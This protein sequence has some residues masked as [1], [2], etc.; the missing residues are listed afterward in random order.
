MQLINDNLWYDEQRQ[1]WVAQYPFLYPRESLLGTKSVAMKS[2]ISTERTLMKNP[3]W[4]ITYQSQIQDMLDRGAAR[5]VPPEELAKF[6]GHIN[7]LPHL[8]VT[9]PNSESTPVRLCFDASR[10]QGGGPSLNKILA[11][12]PDRFLN[13]LAGVILR[14]RNGIVGIKADVKKMYN[15]VLLVEEDCFLQCF[16]WREMDT[17]QEPKTYQVIVNN[18]GVKPAGCIA[19]TALYKSADLFYTKYPDTSKQ[20]KDNSYVDDLGLTARN[21]LEAVERA[22][23]ADEILAHANM[24]VKKWV[25]SG[26]CVEAMDIGESESLPLD[27][28]GTERMLGVLWNAKD[29]EFQ[30]KVRINLSIL[31]KKVRLGP[32]LTKQDLISNPP[33]VL[34]RRQYYSQIQSLFDPIGFLSPVLLVAKILLRKTWKNGCEKLGWDESLPPELV[35]EMIDFF[36]ELFDLELITFSRS[37]LPKHEDVVGKPELV[38]FSDG[39]ILAFGSV[40]YIRWKL[41]SGSWWSKLI[42]SKSK[43]APKSRI[44]VP[45]LELNGACFLT[46][47]LYRVSFFLKFM[48]HVL[49]LSVYARNEILMLNY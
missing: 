49:Q 11:K 3:E 20:L 35:K 6:S 38:I 21:A 2:M 45:R 8:A 26:D 1:S 29:D 13:N 48:L 12:G 36:I 7:Y 19:T 15:A 46:L 41:N 32:D 22:K 14:F 23:Q 25:F 28:V 37:L 39:S 47:C 17:G 40:A 43:I 5:V 34:T 9:N 31:K 24:Q 16:L 30:F 18:I 10:A 33:K 4:G 44:T 27:E 42:L